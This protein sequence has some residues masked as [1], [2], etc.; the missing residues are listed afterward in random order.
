MC[1]STPAGTIPAIV[2]PSATRSRMAV[3]DTS[4]VGASIKMICVDPARRRAEGATIRPA[5]AGSRWRRWPVAAPGL[6]TTAKCARSRINGYSRHVAISANASAPSM[7]KSSPGAYPCSRKRR[8]VSDVNDGNS[9]ASS[10]TSDARQPGRPA[11]AIAAIAKRWNSDADG[12]VRCGGTR[13]GITRTS[14]RSSPCAAAAPAS[15]CPQ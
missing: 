2:S 11:T 4:G 14:V 8:S 12:C 5:S 3:D 15:T 10:S 1:C 13:T 7:K 6:D 9:G